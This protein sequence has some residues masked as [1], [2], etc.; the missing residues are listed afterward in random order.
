MKGRLLIILILLITSAGCAKIGSAPETA[1][2]LVTN[3]PK[4]T[5][6]P[7]QT[8]PPMSPE[9]KALKA[10]LSEHT[11]V[12]VNRLSIYNGSGE[13]NGKKVAY[14]L[15]NLRPGMDF[16]D[17]MQDYVD[18]IYGVFKGDE[19]IDVVR[20]SLVDMTELSEKVEGRRIE[21]V[22]TTDRDT[23]MSLEERGSMTSEEVINHFNMTE[24]TTVA[25]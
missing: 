8:A 23:A 18:V 22:I 4:V 21:R 13:L 10:Y 14:V 17:A 12:S 5:Q 7:V 1:A 25:G 9:E 16:V 3:M 11:E 2:P 24:Y 6:P 15:L 19:T 20:T